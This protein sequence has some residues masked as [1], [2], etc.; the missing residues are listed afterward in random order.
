MS[1]PNF[2]GIGA[3]RSGTSWLYV[4]LRS[5]KDVYM[6]EQK[7]LNFFNDFYSNGIEWY[8]GHFPSDKE[9][10]NYKA[11]GE[12]TPTY[13]TDPEAPSRIHSHIPD[14]RFIAILR[15]PVHRAYS[16]YTKR[17]RDFNFNGTFDEFVERFHEV[18]ARGYY[19]KQ[20]ENYFRV[21]SRDRFLILIFEETVGNH[22]AATQKLSTFLQIDPNGFDLSR[23]QQKVNPSYLPRLPG[24]YS[25]AVK[26]RQSLVKKNLGRVLTAAEK[27]GLIHAARQIVRFRGP[28]S[29]L[30]KMDEKTRKRLSGVYL[31]EI[32][33]LEE[34]LEHDLSTWRN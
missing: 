20:L 22:Q 8:R 31:P 14:C 23:M 18:L 6:S 19:T 13:L 32:H 5:H 34:L 21:F 24:L 10:A 25:S 7:E 12:I 17:L 29:E 1:L 27:L 9:A 26:M 15:N 16:E 4:Q 33:T 28:R 11:V 3:M 30:P 2:L